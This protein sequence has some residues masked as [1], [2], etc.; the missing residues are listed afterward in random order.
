MLKKLYIKW[1]LGKK[2]RAADA[3]RRNLSLY[4]FC[5]FMQADY[6]V[7]V[8]QLAY[9]LLTV[10]SNTSET[11]VNKIQAVQNFARRIVSEAKKYDH[12]TPIFKELKWYL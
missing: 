9:L 10:W 6:N 3:A 4:V 2:I 1:E 5:V 8:S 11:H 7:Q 12:V